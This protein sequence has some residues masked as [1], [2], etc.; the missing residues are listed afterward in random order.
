MFEV[1][2]EKALKQRRSG[3]KNRHT[4]GFLAI[5]E[6]KVANDVYLFCSWYLP[7]K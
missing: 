2:F 1:C 3:N 6:K 4:E 7:K 5:R